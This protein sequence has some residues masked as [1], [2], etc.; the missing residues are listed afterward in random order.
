VFYDNLLRQL[1]E[2]PPEKIIHASSRQTAIMMAAAGLG[3]AIIAESIRHMCLEVV[4]CIPLEGDLSGPDI[5]MGWKKGKTNS[6]AA[7]FEEEL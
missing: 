6:L 5:V 4:D 3:V 1:P 7:F 2:L